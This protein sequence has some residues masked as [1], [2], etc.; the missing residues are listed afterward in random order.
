MIDPWTFGWT[1]LLA[2][3]GLLITVCVSAASLRTLAKWRREKLEGAKIDAAVEA[4]ALA[5]E[6]QFIF[7]EIRAPLVRAHEWKDLEAKGLT[8]AEVRQR[9]SF[10]AISKRIDAHKDFFER[11]W[12]LQPKFMAI[13]GPETATI[14]R[15]VHEA[16][17][18]I[19]LACEMLANQGEPITPDQTDKEFWNQLKADVWRGYEKFAKEGDRV[20][21]SVLAFQGKMEAICN[22]II[23][24]HFHPEKES[25][26]ESLMWALKNF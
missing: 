14:F 20:G 15:L 8:E 19:A 17:K 9:A 22:P 7:D 2:I 23:G 18:S 3:F 12:A 1:Q 10:Y 13:F 24:R 4:L 16:R 25:W 11:L 5:Y 6:A 26:R 21:R